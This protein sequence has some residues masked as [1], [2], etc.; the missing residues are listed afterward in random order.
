MAYWDQRG[1]GRSYGAKDPP[2][3]MAVQQ[4]LQDLDAVVHFLKERFHQPVLLLGHSWGSALAMLYAHARPGAVAAVVGVA[5]VADQGA[6]EKASW[7][8]ALQQARSRNN[9]RAVAELQA[10][11]PPP[12]DVAALATKNHWVDQFGGYL[13]PGFSKLG[14]LLSALWRGETTVSEVRQVIV[15]K[16]FSLNAL[17]PQVH[18]LEK[19]RTKGSSFR[20]CAKNQAMALCLCV[21]HCQSP[22]SLK[23][24]AL[25]GLIAVPCHAHPGII[26]SMFTE[27][28]LHSNIHFPADFVP[29][30]GTA[31]D[32]TECGKGARLDFGFEYAYQ[33]I[34]DLERR[35]IFG[36]E[37]LVRGPQGEGA[38][39]VLAQVNE[40]NRY[41]FD[42]SC[43][44]K[45][46]KGASAL[47]MGE[48]LSI[49]FLPNA[50]Y[51]PE[52][53]I[54]TTLE[55][56]RVHGFPLER[57]IFEVTEGERVEDGP[58]FSEIL[59]EYKR[60]GFKTAI[61][62]FGAGYAGLSLLADFQ[63][64]IIKIDMGLVRNLDTDRSRR[65]IVRNLVRL[66]E[67]MHIEVI[68][69]GVETAGERDALRDAGVFLMQG[70]LFAKPAFRAMAS[71]APS[72]WP[73]LPLA[74]RQA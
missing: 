71:I 2:H 29:L 10:M 52:L 23:K 61:D 35:A 57:I 50:I 21:P 53:C 65:S 55:A 31:R 3:S 37:A 70:Y 33:P 27:T 69:E 43:R 11:G 36:H 5:Q 66:C 19:P 41:R 9:Q 44:V 17:W 42:Q 51:K 48:H 68:G 54:R 45:A 16:D 18:M 26:Y 32:C 63:P 14:V 73:A 72:A 47:G 59:R 40:N 22:E 38:A 28:P 24:A 64:D 20:Q 62:D 13:A 1:A 7:N 4:F 56:A 49:N 67:D 12:L 34:V 6:Q 58:W 25:G 8:W 39:S 15:A 60:C 46:I 74:D 30:T